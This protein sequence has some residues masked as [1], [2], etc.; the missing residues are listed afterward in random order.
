[1]GRRRGGRIINGWINVDK[2]AGMTSASCV[3]IVRRTTEAAKLGH[4]GTLDPSASGVLPMALGEATKTV[5]F[6]VNAHNEYVFTIN[7]GY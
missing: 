6:A 1:M 7:W 3:N 2:P 5:P 4:A